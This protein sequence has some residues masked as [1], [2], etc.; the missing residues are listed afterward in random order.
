[1]SHSRFYRCVRSGSAR[2]WITATVAASIVCV[3]ATA[4]AKLETWRQEGPTAFAKAHREGVVVSDTGRIRLGHA[5]APLGTIGVERVWDLARTREGILLA[6]TGDSG[7]VMGREPKAGASW[8]VVYDCAAGARAGFSKASDTQVLSLCVTPEGI[9]YAGTGPSGQV[10]NLT[11]PKHPVSRPDPKVQYIWDLA[12]DQQGN[13][14][15]ATGP[16]GQLWKRSTQGV[17]SV[18]YD[19][20]SSHL[21]C[22]AVGPDGSIYAGSD[23]EGLIYRVSRDGKATIVFDAPQSEIRTLLW[24]GDGALYAGTAVEAGGGNSGRSSM[25][26]AQGGAPQ[27]LDGGLSGGESPFPPGGADSDNQVKKAARQPGP[28]GGSGQPRNT[29]GRPAGGGSAAPRPITAGD[30]A[31]YRLDADGVPREVLRF[32]ALVHA[33]AWVNDRLIVGTGPEGVLFEVR[34]A[35][36]ETAPIAKLDSGQILS[37]LAEPDGTVLLG[38]GDPGTV[39]RL[40]PGYTPSGSLVSEIHDTKLVSRFG[41][42]SWRAD[43]PADTAITFQ[44]RSGNVGEPDETWSAWSAEQTD[45]AKASTA[46]PAG[47]FIQYRVKLSTNDPRRTPELRSVSL[48]YRTANL[49][50]EITR[51]EIPDVSGGDGA[52][53][54]TRLNIRWDATDPNEDDMSFTLRV[55][56]EGWPEWIKLDSEPLTEK[57]FAWDTTAFPSGSYLLK[58]TATD[59]PSNSADDALSRDRE[60]IT[61]LVDHDPPAVTVTPKGAGASIALKDELTRLVKADYAVDGGTWTPIFPDDE[62]FDSGEEKITLRIP[63]LKR[64]VHLLMVRATDAA[65]NVGTGDGLIEIKD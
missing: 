3:A 13:L 35:G 9:S 18:L 42:L 7:K 47:R 48:S 55:R 20:K 12:C 49:A 34:E 27:L 40:A 15:A 31:V 54:Q 41:V 10:V 61:F 29:P 11:D 51:M 5:L 19:S 23:G 25:F 37:L 2:S 32:K 24:G 26:I 14:L 17:W 50:P 60:S 22:L 62:L 43:R 57:T 6:A 59:R 4:R 65:G 16:N 33:L 38:T 64:G 52:A 46:C 1:M 36:Q 45:P 44:S 58:L 21:L 39:V 56:K 63:D 53:K 30:N 28:S 8:S